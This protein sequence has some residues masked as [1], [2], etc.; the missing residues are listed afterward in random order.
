MSWMKAELFRDL[1][2]IL[3]NEYVDGHM[4]IDKMEIDFEYLLI[5]SYKQMLTEKRKMRKG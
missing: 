2:I 1:K 4:I 5:F 3:P